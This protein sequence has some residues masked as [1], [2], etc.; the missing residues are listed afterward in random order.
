MESY[1]VDLVHGVSRGEIMTSKHFPLGFGAHNIA[2][3]FDQM[4]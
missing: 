4:V 1:A 2:D 3:L